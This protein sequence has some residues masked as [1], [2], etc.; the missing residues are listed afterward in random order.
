MTNE[1]SNYIDD[2]TI[3]VEMFTTY[4]VYTRKNN[5]VPEEVN[6][7]HTVQPTAH[8]FMFFD[9]RGILICAYLATEVVNIEQ[10]VAA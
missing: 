1:Y 10:S 4:Y 7:V 5:G 2:N 9:E 6:G 3:P 8:H